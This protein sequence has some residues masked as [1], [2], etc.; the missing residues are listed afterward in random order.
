MPF[1]ARHGSV[2]VESAMI[3]FGLEHIDPVRLPL[4]RP[5][6]YDL[7]NVAGRGDLRRLSKRLRDL[8]VVHA[9]SVAVPPKSGAALVV[10]VH[11]AASILFPETYTRR[12]RW[13]HR[14]GLRRRR[15]PGR[16]RHRCRRTPRPTRSPSAHRSRASASGSC[17]TASCS[18]RWA[19]VSSR[20]RAR[21]SASATSPTSLW[22][23]TLEPR[24]NVGVLVE[25]FRLLVEREP[26]LPHR[27]V[28]VG[29]TGWLHAADALHDAATALGKRIRFTGPVR[30]D[31][32]LALFRGADLVVLPSL[33]E[34]FGLPVIEAMSQSTAV[35]CSDIPVLHEV[36]GDAARFVTPT[37][38]DAWATALGDVLRDDDARAALAA[39]GRIRASEF[40]WER[41]AERTRALYFEVT[42]R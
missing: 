19:T 17:R 3:A 15:A 35:V 30:D 16:P 20:R 26:D 1:V 10:T 38:P 31:R 41:C 29:P 33:H 34:G 4:P 32:L 5:V 37:D 13:F 14:R 7:W 2:A 39:A 42:G 23:G 27:L 25:A 8:D 6:L 28:I 36:A 40:T 9:P 22:V 11:D 18:A 24:K 21:P 12:G